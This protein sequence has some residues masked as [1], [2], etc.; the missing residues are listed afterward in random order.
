M[1]PPAAPAPARIPLGG[2]RAAGKVALVDAADLPLVAPYRWSLHSTGYAQTSFTHPDGSRTCILMQQLILPD[3]PEVNYKN[4]NKLD[5]RRD[6]LRP[7]THSENR[8]NSKMRTDNES[9]YIGVCWDQARQRW[10]AELQVGLKRLYL[11]RHK[12]AEEAARVRDDAA[13]KHFKEFAVLNFPTDP[14][15]K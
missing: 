4:R 13:K 8:A 2:K 11:G 12:T 7:A 14:A 9:G 6:N 15:E 10:R 5:N 3:A 1:K